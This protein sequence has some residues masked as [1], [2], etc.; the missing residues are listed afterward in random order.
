MGEMEERLS[1]AIQI[2]GV[3]RDF[4]EIY[5]AQEIKVNRP[6]AYYQNE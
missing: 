4:D 2:L 3:N 5:L 1:F 6:V